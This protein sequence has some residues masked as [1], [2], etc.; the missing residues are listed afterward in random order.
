MQRLTRLSERA[1]AVFIHSE[2]EGLVSRIIASEELVPNRRAAL[3]IDDLE[4]P[5]RGVTTES[6]DLHLDGE[7]VT[8]DAAGECGEFKLA[9]LDRHGR[10]RFQFTRHNAASPN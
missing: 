2:P 3:V 10:T 9:I 5:V 7:A 1:Y 8:R 6:I 4:G